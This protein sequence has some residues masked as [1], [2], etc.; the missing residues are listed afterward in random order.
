MITEKITDEFIDKHYFVLDEDYY[1]DEYDGDGFATGGWCCI[2]KGTEWEIDTDENYIGGDVHLNGLTTNE[3][4]EIS[5]ETFR[6][7]FS[8]HKWKG[9][10]E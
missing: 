2:K 5:E 4:V 1:I 9:G 10:V 6:K 8:A 7:I 3:W